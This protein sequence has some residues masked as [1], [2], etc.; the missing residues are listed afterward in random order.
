MSL[1][2]KHRQDTHVE[3]GVEVPRDAGSIPAASINAAL[4][5]FLSAVF[6][7]PLVVSENSIISFFNGC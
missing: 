4:G 7:A 1:E 6:Y 2:L 5:I 3:A